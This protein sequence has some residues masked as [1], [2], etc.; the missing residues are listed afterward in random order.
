MSAD[1]ATKRGGPPQRGAKAGVKTDGPVWGLSLSTLT[2]LC[3]SPR[4]RMKNFGERET[5][6]NGLL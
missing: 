6:A 2:D 3:H 1:G 5:K 4:S